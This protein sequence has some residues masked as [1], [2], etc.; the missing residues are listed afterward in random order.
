MGGVNYLYTNILLQ[1]K[2]TSQDDFALTVQ[3]NSAQLQV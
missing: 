1:S 3:T 2:I